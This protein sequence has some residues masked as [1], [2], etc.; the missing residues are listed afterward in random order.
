MMNKEQQKQIQRVAQEYLEQLQGT[1]A[2]FMF[3]GDEGNCFTTGGIPEH[4][5]AQV[6][7]AMIRYPIVKEIIDRCHNEYRRLNNKMGDEIRNV[8]MTHLIEKYT[9]K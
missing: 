5:E 6:I 2:S 9:E 8:T 1:D 7:F 4:I 3:V